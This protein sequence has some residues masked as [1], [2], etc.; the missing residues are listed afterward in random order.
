MMRPEGA[1]GNTERIELEDGK[2][3]RVVADLYSGQMLSAVTDMSY[4]ILSLVPK[5]ADGTPVADFEDCI[6]YDGDRELKAWAGIAKYVASFEAG[7][8][9]IANVPG[10]YGESQGRK[11]AEDKKDLGSLVEKPNRYAVMII[12]AVFLAVAAIAAIIAVIIKMWKKAAGR[13]AGN[14]K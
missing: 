12:A 1:G 10:Y 7:E 6:I 9:G 4:G 3:Y 11:V 14:G 2:L 8:D 5:H 13:R